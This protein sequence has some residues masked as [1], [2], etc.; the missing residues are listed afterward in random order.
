MLDGRRESR[1]RIV[2]CP[3][4]YLI[5]PAACSARA[6]TV[7][8][9]RSEPNISAKPVCILRSLDRADIAVVTLAKQS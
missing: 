2:T 3:R 9:V 1:S 5:S 4:E 6:V 7:T 8:V